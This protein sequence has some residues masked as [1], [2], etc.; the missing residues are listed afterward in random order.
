MTLSFAHADF[1]KRKVLIGGTKMHKQKLSYLQNNKMIPGKEAFITHVD[2]PVE[3]GSADMQLYDIFPGIQL[4][5]SEFA[6][7]TC[8]KNSAKQ[9]VIGINHC[10]RGR[11]ECEFD[12][13]SYLYMGEGDIAI[14][15]MVRPPVGSSFPLNYYFGSTI[16][17]FTEI[18][19]NVP[20][21]KAFGIDVKQI[22]EK[23]ALD[24]KNPVFRRNDSVE[25]VYNELYDSLQEPSLPF[26]RIKILELLYHFQSRQIVLEENQEY[27]PKT[28]TEKIKLV[29]EHMIG[30]LEHRVSLKDLAV[31][32][33]LS[34]TQL[35][36][37]FKQIYGETPYAYLR[38]YKMH[39]AARMLQQSDCKISEVALELGYQNPSKF[40]EAFR[41]VMGCKPNQYR[42]QLKE[43]K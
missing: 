35:K 17:L 8:Y 36:S 34:L 26:L 25:H 30:D 2:F 21:L 28:L 11:F 7:D 13:R 20:E 31:E 16:I 14:S 33:E 3:W 39:I 41:T 19:E 1:E 4:M 42:A 12:S 32:H 9:N 27:L 37:G 10:S 29:K 22:F 38:N 5:V 18:C 24:V 15:S 43:N 6:T 40:T 23:Y